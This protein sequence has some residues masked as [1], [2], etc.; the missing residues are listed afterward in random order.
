MQH[1][2][3]FCEVSVVDLNSEIEAIESGLLEAGVTLTKFC[4]LAKISVSTWTRWR[5]GVV[6]PNFSTWSR[7]EATYEDMGGARSK[8]V[9][10][11]HSISQSEGAT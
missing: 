7:V 1:E 5:S 2:V 11:V 6:A 4:F 9:S 10:Q 3:E 8:D